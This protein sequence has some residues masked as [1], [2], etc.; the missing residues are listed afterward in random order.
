MNAILP[1]EMAWR[2]GRIAARADRL[3]TM[4]QDTTSGPKSTIHCFV[5]APFERLRQD[6]LAIFLANRLQP[7]IGLDGDCLWQCDDADFAEIAVR[8]RDEG[9]ACTLHAPFT[10]LAPGGRE[11]RIVEVSRDKLR[12]AFALIPVFRPRSI[13]CHLGYEPHR[14]ADRFDEWL[15]NSVATWSE[16]VPIAEQTGTRVLFENTYE[17][18][19]HG[20]RRLLEALDTGSAGFCLD[21]GHLLAF[22]GT[23]WRPWLDELEPWLGQL[24]L[25]DND[26]SSDAHLAIGRGVFDFQGLFDFL[27]RRD[28]QP[29]ITLEPHS[30]EDLW[31]SL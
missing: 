31:Q 13:V 6:L 11:A 18:G 1:T 27:R 21:V 2:T 5:N 4:K 26:G 9:L 29:L 30:E 15:Q 8:L 20:H 14:H 19:P 16:L 22:A 28:H 25:H 23:G 10:D 17:Q 24:H 3:R 7:E 12:R